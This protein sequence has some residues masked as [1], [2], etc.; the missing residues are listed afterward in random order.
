MVIMGINMLGVF[1][2][3]RRFNLRMPKL[4][5]RR[6]EHEKGGSK[7]P[8]YIGLL[9]GLMPC[10]PLQAMQLYALST[11][12]PLKGGLSMFLFSLGT[13]P[14]MW[15]LGALSSV[16][17]KRFTQKVMTVGAMLV[18]ILGLTMFSNGWSLSGLSFPLGFFGGSFATTGAGTADAAGFTIEDGVQIV[19]SSLASGRYPAITVEAG[20]PVKWT[21]DAPRGSING[22]NNRMIIPEYNIEHTFQTG[23]NVIEFTPT[24]TG[25]FRYS[26]WMG[27]IRSTI[28]VLEPGQTEF[29]GVDSAMDD[30]IDEPAE[31]V[32]AGFRIPTGD[33]GIAVMET[34]G[35][36]TI[37]KITIDVTD[38]GFS[39]AAVI[40]QEGVATALL[41]NNT[42]TR[43]EN[44]LLRFPAYGQELPLEEGLN[45]LGLYPQEDFDFSTSDSEYYGYVKVVEDLQNIDMEAIKAEIG[46][47]QTMMY[48]SDYFQ[49]PGGGASCH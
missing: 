44:Y 27:M 33:M 9:N 26:C 48:P 35:R 24:R 30:F 13:V 5:A 19:N 37:Q 23:V 15:G 43:E 42:S 46:N 36:R 14:L 11:G 25:K 6:I 17:S 18:V 45:A 38:K 29:A 28:T 21:I 49:G 20:I 16:L 22:C 39:P 10:G 4:F 12:S 8:L 47:F 32:P 41:F 31:P 34:E 40:I 2:A 3:L 7:S 1:P